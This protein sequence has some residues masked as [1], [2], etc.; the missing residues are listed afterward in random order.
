LEILFRTP[1][2]QETLHYEIPDWIILIF[3]YWEKP[4]T[5]IFK[6]KSLTWR[7]DA[8]YSSISKMVRELDI[9]VMSIK[10][11]KRNVMNGLDM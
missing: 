8:I 4:G 10:I 9:N 2:R 11:F 5:N 7:M 1:E 6:K 3:F